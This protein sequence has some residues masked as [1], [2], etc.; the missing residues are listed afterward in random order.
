MTDLIPQFGNTLWTLAAFIAA[1]SIIVTVH[2]YGHYIVGRWSGIKAEVFSIGFGP[3]IASRRDRRGT[4]WQIAAVP[5]GGYVRFLGDSNAASAGPGQAVDPAERRRTLDGAPLWARFATVAAG[6]AFNFIF[7]TL[8]FA[9]F[10]L[11]IGVPTD[12]VQI[13]KID[14][15]P[16]SMAHEL[17]PGDEILMVGD[18][19]VAKWNDI[20]KAEKHL[21]PGPQDW[22][23]RR[24]GVEMVVRGPDPAPPVI[25]GISPRSAAVA[26]GLRPGDVVLSIQDK[27]VDR[28]MQLRESVDAAEGAPLSLVV[29]REGLG[30]SRVT[31]TARK[32]DTPAKDGGFEQRWLM[33]INGGGPPFIPTTRAAGPIEALGIG[34]DKTWDVIRSSVVGIGAMIAGQISSCNL[35]GAITIADSTGQAASF[36]LENFIRWIAVLSAAIGFLNLLPVPVLDGGHLAFFT[37]EAVTGRRPSDRALHLLTAIG[38]AM[39]LTLMIF[40][41]TN[42]IFCR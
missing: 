26:A 27:P 39:V 15:L 17:R 23:I 14:P 37:Y 41:L 19:E 42:D 28:F 30:E 20:E 13:G 29:W 12:K 38:L 8:I 4:V 1:L 22:R 21:P 34:V 9:G 25:T 5:L 36:G 24:D 10:A 16:P 35:G 31:L 6:P 2:E 18:Q 7:S 32:R 3:V 40:G 11:W 33:G